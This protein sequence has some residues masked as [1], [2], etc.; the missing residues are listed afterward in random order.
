[1]MKQTLEEVM[2]FNEELCQALSDLTPR[3]HNTL[4]KFLNLYSKAVEK[5]EYTILKAKAMIT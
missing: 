2:K 3:N 1:M 4:E 5:H